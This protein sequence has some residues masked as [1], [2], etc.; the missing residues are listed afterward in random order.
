MSDELTFIVIDNRTGKAADETEIA[1]R[2]PWARGLTYCDTEGF[3]L[4]QD[5]SLVLMDS[6]GYYVSC[7]AGRFTIRWERKP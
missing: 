2:E 1:L 5:G 6:G 3:A 7:P 4:A